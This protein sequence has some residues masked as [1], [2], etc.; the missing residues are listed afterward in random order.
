MTKFKIVG[1]GA[2]GTHLAYCLCNQKKCTELEIY[3]FD[4]LSEK[5]I[6][7][8]PFYKGMEGSNKVHAFNTL[9]LKMHPDIKIHCRPYKFDDIESIIEPGWIAIDCRD[10]KTLKVE[11]DFRISFD[12]GRLIIDSRLKDDIS[13]DFYAE[14]DYLSKQDVN[15]YLL[16]T[17]H[18]CEY[19]DTRLFECKKFVIYTI[20][21]N[22]VFRRR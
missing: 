5:D 14:S 7:I 16:A 11:F 15:A 3:D 2:I 1:L 18:C 12:G 20:F 13:E 19:I 17:A 6:E 8:F 22:G 9:M 21:K 4:F 10:V